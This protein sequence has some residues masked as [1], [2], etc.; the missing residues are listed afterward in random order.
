MSISQ[1]QMFNFIQG[2]DISGE[3]SYDIWKKFNDGTEADFLEYL[4]SGPQ[5]I[6]GE[7]GQPGRVYI[8]DTSDIVIKKNSE[9]I[10]VPSQI[11]FK[12]FY[13]EGTSEVRNSY[14]GRFVIMETTDNSLWETKYISSSDESEKI[15]TPSNAEVK[16]IK[17]VLYS[18]GGTTTEID[19]QNIAV[20]SEASSVDINT[21]DIEIGAR[22]LLSGSDIQYVF[23]NAPSECKY[24]SL[25][26]VDGFDLQRLVGKKVTL[27]FYVDTPGAYD[28]CTD[29]DEDI[30]R[31]GVSLVSIW[32]DSTNINTGNKSI[33]DNYY[34][35]GI[36]K[37]RLSYIKELLPPTGYDTLE[38]IFLEVSLEVQPDSNN[39]NTWVFSRPKLEI[40]TLA[41][42]WTP[43]P[44]DIESLVALLDNESHVIATDGIG[45]N[46]DYSNCKT[47]VQIFSGTRD[48]T[49]ECAYTITK[50]DGITG[51][52]DESSYTYIVT[53]MTTDTGCVNISITYRGITII[54]KFSLSKSKSGQSTYDVW[55]SLGNEG[56]AQDFLEYIKGKDGKSAYELALKYGFEGTEEEFAKLSEGRNITTESIPSNN[57]LKTNIMY[58]LG[59]INEEI[60]ISLPESAD[61]GDMISISFNTGATSYDFSIVTNNH[62][63]L[64]GFSVIPNYYYELIC[65]W[66]GLVW[67]FVKNEVP[68]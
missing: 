3:S 12:G 61:L 11:T 28:W 55:K 63:G 16:N 8:L 45:N 59:T 64:T 66:N 13:R 43:A 46:G 50:S 62:I 21:L 25:E 54:K 27:S 1:N 18:A 17:C 26:I 23:T 15:Y 35:T 48:V 65:M 4:R 67:S 29:A 32:S 56:D 57:I 40:G 52:W 9:N 19:S 68:K 6:K 14:S 10:L 7:V 37:K 2:S 31:F 30:E 20:I 36:S 38:S 5:G 42:D 58:F 41:T 22:N 53:N 44:E 39:T 33:S 24:T 47:T 60:S 51:N 49:E 34:S